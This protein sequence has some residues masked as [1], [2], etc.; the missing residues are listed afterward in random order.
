MCI[1]KSNLSV[2]LLVSQHE[3]NEFVVAKVQAS[4]MQAVMQ[5]EELGREVAGAKTT[6]ASCRT[7][8]LV[9]T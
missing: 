5:W 3:N 6:L 9:Q 4:P 1:I 8:A 2:P 7:R